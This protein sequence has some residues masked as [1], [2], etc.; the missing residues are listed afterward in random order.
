MLVIIRLLRDLGFGLRHSFRCPAG[1]WG[2]PA[3]PAPAA[4]AAAAA[5]ATATAAVSTA[6]AAAV[7]AAAAVVVVQSLRAEPA[8][9]W[10]AVSEALSRPRSMELPDCPFDSS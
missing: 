4:A 6:P 7:A 1:D 2:S 3:A 5:A 10:E 9:L 8:R